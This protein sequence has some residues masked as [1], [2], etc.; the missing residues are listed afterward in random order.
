MKNVAVLTGDLIK[1][2]SLNTKEH[3]QIIEY[4]K[5]LP[6]RF[7]LE[8]GSV[9]NMDVFRGDS[10]QLYIEDFSQAIRLAVYLRA[11]LKAHPLR[12]LIDTRVGIG[13]G[14][15]DSLEERVSESL[16]SAFL[17][18][19]RVLEEMC[20]TN[21]LCNMA[22]D[23][24]EDFPSP[25]LS[26][27][28]ALRSTYLPFLNHHVTHLTFIESQAVYA[29]LLSKTQAETAEMFSDAEN[30]VT[31]Q[32]INKALKRAKWKELIEPTLIHQEKLLNYS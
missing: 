15:V 32:S 18:S 11:G 21:G 4:F 31:Q 2:Q 26:H 29:A 22:L 25:A 24:T 1:S 10:W 19:G 14:T 20:G 3:R 9:S 28:Q 30:P 8:K 6:T 12:H 16:G 7:P 5:E 23:V 17:V 13:Y 27:L